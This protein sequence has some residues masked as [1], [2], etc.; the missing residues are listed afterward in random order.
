MPPSPLENSDDPLSVVISS[1]GVAL[2]AVAALIS[3][4]VHRAV[5]TVPIATLV[6]ADGNM[7]EGTFP[8]SDSA[9]L[10][11][12]T[13]IAV[14]AGYGGAEA[15]IF[16][17]IV[18]KHGI[19]IGGDNDARLVIE[20]HD[21]AV[22]MT[23]ARKSTLHVDTNDADILTA[24]IGT[25]GLTPE[26]SGARLAHAELIQHDCTDWDFLLARAAAN[27]CLVIVTD[28]QVAVAPPTTRGSAALKVTYGADLIEF[29]AEL[30][31]RHQYT[32]VQASAWEGKTQSLLE[33]A[34]AGPAQLN[35]QGNLDS[36]TLAEVL[37]IGTVKWQTG[38][39]LPKEALDAWA[40][41]RQLASGLS[42]LRGRMRFQG[43]ALAEVGGLVELAGVGARF[44]GPVFGTGLT[45]RI[46]AG[47]WTT[48]LE[49]GMPVEG[50]N[51]PPD[52]A[53][54]AAVGRAPGIEGL[55]VG[56]VLQLDADPA[57]EHR[58]KVRLPAAGVGGVWARLMQFQASNAFGALFV[59]EVGD[60]VLLGFL[61]SDPASPVVLGSLYSSQRPPPHALTA[62]NDIKSIVTRSRSRLEFN[63]KD[64]TIT[65]S[66]PG[67]NTV[68]L[69][70]RDQS[71]VLT[72]QSGN[73]VRLEP[74]GITLQSPKN[75]TI[76]AKGAV[77][78]SA[79]GGLA[80]RAN[81]DVTVQGLNIDCEAQV[82]LTARGS[83][84]AE[85]SAQ[86]MT[87]VKGAMVM[88]N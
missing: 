18:V 39:A 11:P 87:T 20:C 4:T 30:D 32:G 58:V 68:V 41:A 1:D 57:G 73:L 49:F 34:V 27:G 86:G 36:A 8:L 85:L 88:I 66:T 77:S 59:P 37:G 84:S 63:D 28:G 42:R 71:I 33:G 7:R 3:I 51:G 52:P 79:V 9:L 82:G 14:Q 47:N 6:F 60:E 70:D 81:A 5:N 65:V 45:H 12:G 80:L 21:K 35:P 17:G 74:A 62:A 19:T 61:S 25:Y 55:Q 83:A 50:F 23:V 38:A 26:V 76:E 22:K 48:D 10:K 40:K 13:D 15:T 16:A 75:I 46:E 43:S 31:A 54:P 72:D 69:S 29:E 24:L 44:S 64:K 67:R 2:S 53:V 78:I 56:V